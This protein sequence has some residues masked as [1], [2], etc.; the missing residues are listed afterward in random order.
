MQVI[1]IPI[2]LKKNQTI[3]KWPT[4]HLYYF[5]MWSRSY[6]AK[7][8][9]PY[10]TDL[11]HLPEWTF[12]QKH[13][14]VNSNPNLNPNPYPNSNPN[15]QVP[16]VFGKTKR[17]HFWGKCP[18]TSTPF[19]MKGSLKW[20]NDFA[21]I[22]INLV[23]WNTFTKIDKKWGTFGNRRWRHNSIFGICRQIIYN[24]SIFSIC[25]FI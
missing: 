24:K 11:V 18:G 1:A 22:L 8:V 4:C 5:Q 7:V 12:D 23:A 13:I 17:H 25:S 21:L 9:E 16:N 15:L 19:Y 2:W 6:I 14:F 3:L 20:K 10:F